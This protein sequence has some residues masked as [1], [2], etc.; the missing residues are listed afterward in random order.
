VPRPSTLLVRLL[1]PCAL[2]G[3]AVVA[4]PAHAASHSARHP[5]LGRPA[6]DG[7]AVAATTPS[8]DVDVVLPLAVSPAVSRSVAA[9][10]HAHLPVP[11]RRA[12]LRALA[13][14][15]E[16]SR[17]VQA[18]AARH[19]F[20]V[21]ATTPWSVALR[22]RA[23]DL[24]GAFGTALRSTSAQGTPFVAPR[25][26]A[27]VPRELAGLTAPAIGLD[28]RPIWSGRAAYGGGDVQVLTSTPVRGS[29]AGQGATVA[30]VNLSGWHAADLTTYRRAAF[31]NGD[32]APTVTSVTVGQGHIAATVLEDDL[33]AETEVAL[34]AEAIAG[35]APAA[36]Q[37]MYFGAN[38]QADYLL[39][40]QRM[41]ADLTDL[42][43]T[44]DFQ[45]ASTSW[46]A[47]E[48]GV[49]QASL[50]AMRSAISTITAAGATFF[51]ASGDDGA[52]GCGDGETPAVDF[53]ASAEDAVA[54]GGL[55]VHTPTPSYEPSAWSGS[56]G[57]CSSRVPMPFRQRTSGSP[58]S[59][60]AVP[61]IASIADPLTGFWAYDFADEWLPVGGT[62][63]AAP[64]S[65]AG[66]ADMMADTHVS[67]LATPFLDTAYAHPSAFYDVFV[68][69]N[70]LYRA[71]PGYDLTTGLGVP[72]WTKVEAAVTGGA[73]PTPQGYNQPLL[74]VDPSSDPT[75]LALRAPDGNDNPIPTLIAN[76]EPVTGY[77]TTG[78]TCTSPTSYVPLTTP[79]PGTQGTVQLAMSVAGPGFPGGCL[80]VTRSVVVDTPVPTAPVPVVTYAGTTSPA[81]RF[82]WGVAGDSA[83]SSGI[84]L[85]AAFV[86]DLTTGTDV[87]SFVTTGRAFP[88]PASPAFK[89]V[90]GHA[91]GIE[92]DAADRAWNVGYRTATFTA[93]Y[94][95]TKVALSKHL[96][97]STYVSDWSRAKSSADYLGSHVTSAR[98]G[99]SFS[100]G[101]TAKTVTLGVL[102]TPAGGYA[103][104]YLDGV[105][106]TRISLYASAN[107]YR[108]PVRVASYA[109]V[110]KHAL[111]V[112]VVGAHTAA[113]KGSYVYLDSVTLAS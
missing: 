58:C 15:A 111:K 80:A 73:E 108:Q 16:Q 71:T 95:D 44:N 17:R 48:L 34:D 65:A 23:A 83:P 3:S 85:Y 4:A 32:V 47:C 37:R 19:G 106:K 66:L 61:D 100:F 28:T 30:T 14:S 22:G 90:P 26:A 33:G 5:A 101:F 8:S 89:A 46:G 9:L 24:A 74:A 107:Q 67:S 82:S 18:W 35:V 70:G 29:A 55:T 7:V 72:L 36:Q 1:V 94:D 113:S 63:V 96:S 87:A 52:F 69:D 93:P 77:D 103:D 54:V 109:T 10:T 31:G 11:V 92:V 81:Y 78:S 84:V 40:L 2:L 51:A 6:H 59:G 86:T 105:R 68:G 21:I 12:R 39:V 112:V 64:A 42:D 53:P 38:S 20:A 79:L 104:V 88:Y 99:A 110:G 43:A 56:G 97:G 76:G 49:P 13:P 102:R 50:D 60:R 27:R 41:A 75:T 91:Y 25:T 98:T 45:T 57:G 62:S